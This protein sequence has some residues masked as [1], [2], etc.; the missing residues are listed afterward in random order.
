MKRVW[1]IRS[2]CGAG[3]QRADRLQRNRGAP[4]F[5]AGIPTQRRHFVV[6]FCNGKQCQQFRQFQQFVEFQQCKQQR[7]WRKLRIQLD[8]CQLQ[9]GRDDPVEVSEI[10]QQRHDH[11]L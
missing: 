7:Q 9:A 2:G 1:L 10:R 8:R 6:Q 11:G 5:P 4:R 3:S